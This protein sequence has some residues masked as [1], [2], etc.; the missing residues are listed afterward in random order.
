[1][2]KYVFRETYMFATK[3][4]STHLED[5]MTE[6][7]PIYLD[8][9]ATTPVDPRVAAL[10]LQLMLE[11][12][13]N[14]GSRTH[15]YGSRAK[16]AVEA[17]RTQIARVVEADPS[18]VIFTSGATEA[19]N[20]AIL[21]LAEHGQSIGRMHVVST[22]LEH[23]A[24]LEPIG[25]LEKHGFSVD[26]IVADATGAVNS[27][28]VLAAI[29]PDTLLVSVMHVNNETG[30]RQP[31]AAIADA[32]SDD[33]VFLHTDSA[34]GF[35]KDLEP[36]RNQRIDMIS[37]SGHK[38]FGPKGV[39]A[40][41]ARRRGRRRPPL[42]PLMHG[43]G[44][45]RGLRPGTLPVPLIAGFGLAADL[46]GREAAVRRTRTIEIRQRIVTELLQIG[47]VMNGEDSLAVP[48]IVNISFP[49]LDSEAVILALRTIAAVSNGSACTSSNYEPSHVLTAMG[50][51]D[52]RRRG[53]IRLSWGHA[54]PL[55][56]VG[57]MARAVSALL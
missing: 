2:S 22:A 56:E 29:R 5:P 44:Q 41:I 27:D 3:G 17:A 35:G 18:E 40:L 23:K 36:L 47:A 31:V 24:V 15:E 11:D 8:C 6:A 39:G 38:V 51:D 57:A 21:G 32:L 13:G 1:M 54:T 55:P 53:A 33:N 37:I 42:Q 9:A 45:E 48:H 46:A 7:N 12:F 25:F 19:N 16:R 43:G 4:A 10:V 14:A 20:L 30:V 50:L 28:E 34:Q 49:G 26:L 52:E